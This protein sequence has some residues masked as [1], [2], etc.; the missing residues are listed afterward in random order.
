MSGAI[1]KNNS[2]MK[3]INIFDLKNRSSVHFFYELFPWNFIV[4]YVI[5]GTNASLKAAGER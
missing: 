5:P 3:H 2:L 1:G 4:S